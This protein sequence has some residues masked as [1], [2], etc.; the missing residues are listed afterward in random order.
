M[1]PLFGTK[2]LARTYISTNEVEPFKELSDAKFLV[3][4]TRFVSLEVQKEMVLEYLTRVV[5]ELCP[6]VGNGSSE[7]T[8]LHR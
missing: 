4:P 1:C 5:K 7:Q 6:L 3:D 8:H 2:I